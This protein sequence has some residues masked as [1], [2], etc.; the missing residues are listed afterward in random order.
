MVHKEMSLTYC[1]APCWASRTVASIPCRPP[2]ACTPPPPSRHKGEHI[3]I[4]IF[5]YIRMLQHSV[6]CGSGIF[7]SDL[8]Q[9]PAGWLTNRNGHNPLQK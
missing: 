3:Y 2:P 9:N 4:T 5:M 6:E 8:D 1:R 7:S